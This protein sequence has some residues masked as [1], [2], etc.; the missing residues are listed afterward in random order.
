[1]AAD[2]IVFGDGKKLPSIMQFDHFVDLAA[3]SRPATA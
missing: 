1:M 2:C 3:V